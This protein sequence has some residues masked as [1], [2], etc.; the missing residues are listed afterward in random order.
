MSRGVSGSARGEDAELVALRV[1]EAPPRH[2]ALADVDTGGTESPQPGHLRR[3][4]VTGVRQQVEM[5]A[6][7]PSLHAGRAEDLPISAVR[8]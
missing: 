3:L 7:P 4:I 5:N 6:V 2:V 1:G 8:A